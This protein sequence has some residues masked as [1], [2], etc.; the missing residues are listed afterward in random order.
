[1]AA[2]SG[3]DGSKRPLR[4]HTF[5]REDLKKAGQALLRYRQKQIKFK[6]QAKAKEAGNL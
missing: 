5:D 4:Y 6:I 2:G 1:M 3:T